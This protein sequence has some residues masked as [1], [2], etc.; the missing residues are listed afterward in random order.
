M[1]QADDSRK[2]GDNVDTCFRRLYE[3]I[4]QA[5]RDAVPGE[6]SVEQK[7]RVEDLQKAE[8]VSRRKLKEHLSKKKGARRGGG[9]GED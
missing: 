3:L 1:I 4:T 8:Q 2:Q 5:G 7:Q 6:T 9:G